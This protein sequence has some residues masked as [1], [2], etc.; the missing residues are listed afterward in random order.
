MARRTR[1]Q[2]ADDVAPAVDDDQ[3][4]RSRDLGVLR[5]EPEILSGGYEDRPAN[6]DEQD[7]DAQPTEDF[8]HHG[9][10]I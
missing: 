8:A 2:V 5:V 10:K 1:R 6:Q 3:I 7:G 4:R 9:A